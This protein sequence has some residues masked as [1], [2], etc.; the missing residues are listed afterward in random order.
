LSAAVPGDILILAGGLLRLVT[1][2]AGLLL[3]GGAGAGLLLRR[4]G[5]EPAAVE[6]A[7]RR[8]A[9][10][11]L[12]ILIAA[13]VPLALVETLQ[14]TGAPLTLAVLTDLL[15]YMLLNT[16]FGVVWAAHAA[17]LGLLWV[18]L[19]AGHTPG[20]I[21]ALA[22]LV[23]WPQLGHLAPNFAILAPDT[24]AELGWLGAHRAGAALWPGTLAVLLAWSRA[25]GPVQRPWGAAFFRLA[26]P[27]AGLLLGGAAGVLLDHGGVA[28]LTG[29]TLFGSLVQ[30]KIVL[31]LGL[32]GLGVW[33]FRR[34]RSA[35][36]PGRGSLAAEV[37]VAGAAVAL[38]AIL[39]VLPS[40][41]S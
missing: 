16:L 29:A 17:I 13:L 26:L 35:A 19:R 2:P 7:G 34:Y 14:Q 33:H 11:L 1:L 22:L 6:R 25:G 4:L 36:T 8:L 9:R 5:S 31:L 38:G 32:L 39:G 10:P 27:G 15:P 41:G 21:G 12:L 18:R 24:L 40:P 3:G 30:I 23:A 20:L 28:T 37:A